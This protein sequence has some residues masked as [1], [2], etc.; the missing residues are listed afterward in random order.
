MLTQLERTSRTSWA[1]NIDQF[2][3]I[4]PDTEVVRFLGHTARRGQRA[5]LRA[6]DLGCGG[7]RHL[8]CMAREGFEVYGVDYNPPSL[9]LARQAVHAEGRTARLV[10]ADIA[11][12]PFADEQFDIVVAW[13]VLFNTTPDRTLVMMREIRRMLKP[14][15]RLLAN[16]RTV[17]D[18]LR[19][20]G[21]QVAEQTYLLDE[22]ADS[23]GLTGTLYTFS[24]RN[25]L[26]RVYERADLHVDN[27]ERHD[28]WINNL[29]I[30]CSWWI[31]WATRTC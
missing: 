26:D 20:R 31:V 12:P 6:L 19:H 10:T 30:Y 28:S 4:W 22:Q 5:G 3:L 21:K 15:G 13:G 14:G 11:V 16:W 8:A 24:T 7:G 27:V 17:E 2:R 18:D 25:D 29:S 9:E 23:L 1:R